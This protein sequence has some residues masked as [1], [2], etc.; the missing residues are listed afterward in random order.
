MPKFPEVDPEHEVERVN[1]RLEKWVWD[2]LRSIAK[3]EGRSLNQV[4]DFFLRWC[5]EDYKKI[6]TAESHKGKK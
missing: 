2:E 6:A 3:A 5:I 1:T 4:V